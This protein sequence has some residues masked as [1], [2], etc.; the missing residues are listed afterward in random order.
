MNLTIKHVSLFLLTTILFISSVSAQPLFEVQKT[1]STENERDTQSSPFRI[2]HAAIV[3]GNAPAFRMPD[4]N[5]APG[6]HSEQPAPPVF[7]APA[8]GVDGKLSTDSDS[9]APHRTA[10]GNDIGAEISRPSEAEGAGR[11]ETTLA[12]SGS[13]MSASRSEEAKIAPT[14]DPGTKFDTTLPDRT[15]KV[16]IERTNPWYRYMTLGPDMSR[17]LDECE[18]SLLPII[19]VPLNIRSGVGD[20]QKR[21]HTV[22]LRATNNERFSSFSTIYGH[23][24]AK[25]GVIALVSMSQRV[26]RICNLNG[27]EGQALFKFPKGQL[28]CLGAGTEMI[29][30]PTLENMSL[31]VNDGLARRG[32]VRLSRDGQLQ[33]AFAQFSFES[34]F[35]LPEVK[36]FCGTQTQASWAV[37]QKT[38]EYLNGVRGTT[39]F[40]KAIVMNDKLATAHKPISPDQKIT[41]STSP[42]NSALKVKRPIAATA[43]E[44]PA[45]KS[46]GESVVSAQL[47][48]SVSSTPAKGNAADGFS[49]KFRAITRIASLHKNASAVPPGREP[50]DRAQKERGQKQSARTLRTPLPPA[51]SRAINAGSVSTPSAGNGVVIGRSAAQPTPLSTNLRAASTA[52]AGDMSRNAHQ[53]KAPTLYVDYRPTSAPG[54]LPAVKRISSGDPSLSVAAKELILNAER[55]ERRALA[56]RKQSK[57]NSEFMNCGFLNP[58]QSQRMANETSQLN[59]NATLA[60]EKALK[61]RTEA[62]LA[63]KPG[64]SAM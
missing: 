11:T 4:L 57:R 44:P 19:P 42:V 53:S 37:L 50:V 40:R 1:D 62:Q 9:K 34:F 14:T 54:A 48:S 63:G 13:S 8:T 51:D 10:T 25:S 35:E 58:Q 6:L 32:I 43:A 30:A 18:H 31:N 2:P 23:L 36:Y 45:V 7:T 24:Y 61:L 55:E 47:A 12:P 16:S 52:T 33:L 39:G 64:T 59:V 29:I 26:V 28:I 46:S 21:D 15:A 38:A 41:A 3:E 17:E 22:L 27:R 56:L 5:L 20:P 49:S 60:E